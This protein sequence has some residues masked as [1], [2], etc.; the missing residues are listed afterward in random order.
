M[1]QHALHTSIN[2]YM[3]VCMHTYI[4]YIHAC[5]HTYIAYIQDVGRWAFISQT[6]DPFLRLISVVMQVGFQCTTAFQ[7][8]H[9]D[10]NNRSGQNPQ[11]TCIVHWEVRACLAASN[12]V[13]LSSPFSRH[14]IRD[15]SSR[16]NG[17]AARRLEASWDTFVLSW[18]TCRGRCQHIPQIIYTY[19][20]RHAR[21][22]NQYSKNIKSD[23]NFVSKA[24]GQST[25]MWMMFDVQ[26]LK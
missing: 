1:I 2:K 13:T 10:P 6:P 7:I 8:S 24:S 14:S 12:S 21:M 3:H 18:T 17:G 11:K 16:K 20:Y 22:Q 26:K 4:A 25:C 5:R 23:S 19:I 9:V 15:W